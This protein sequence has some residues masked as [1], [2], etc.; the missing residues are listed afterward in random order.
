MKRF[1]KIALIVIVVIVV[2]AQLALVIPEI[3]ATITYNADPPPA[4]KPPT[5]EGKLTVH[6]YDENGELITS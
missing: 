6:F 3:I 2:G 5:F 4:Y 1:L